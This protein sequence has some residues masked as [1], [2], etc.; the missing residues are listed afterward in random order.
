MSFV[1]L[2]LE[3][4]SYAAFDR[5]RVFCIVSKMSL[6]DDLQLLGVSDSLRQKFARSFPELSKVMPLIKDL[7]EELKK[8][9][10]EL[11][12][13]SFGDGR[14]L[15]RQR[16]GNSDSA[17]SLDESQASD[18]SVLVLRNLSCFP[19]RTADLHVGKRSLWFH[20]SK[21]GVIA[22]L[23]AGEGKL[24]GICL[25]MPVDTSDKSCTFFA[26]CSLVTL[27]QANGDNP[28]ALSLCFKLNTVDSKSLKGDLTYDRPA[29]KQSSITVKGGSVKS[30]V[31]EL[32]SE[33][34]P[35][36]W[37]P[38][39]DICFVTV[40]SFGSSSNASCFACKRKVQDSYVYLLDE[41]FL[42]GFGKPIMYIPLAHILSVRYSDVVRSSF[43]ATLVVKHLASPL[44][45]TQISHTHYEPLSR[46]FTRHFPHW[47]MAK[48]GTLGVA[49]PSNA[50]SDEKAGEDKFDDAKGA[51][52]EDSDA[53]DESDDEYDD[54][55]DDEDGEDDDESDESDDG[56]ESD[57]SDRDD[58]DSDQSILR[59]SGA[60][61][62]SEEV[63]DE[64]A[65][66]YSSEGQGRPSPST[67]G[68]RSL[69]LKS[70]KTDDDEEEIGSEDT[71]DLDEDEEDD[72]DDEEDDDDDDEDDKES[73]G[74][75]D[76][77]EDD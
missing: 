9:Y 66:A 61:T 46:Y 24:T 37:V 45:L 23:T 74:E 15:K 68:N 65:E 28:Y 35:L 14:A 31:C 75:D 5:R 33:S 32:L 17:G 2:S 59:D 47:K 41:G 10:S 11:G 38:T 29:I 1:L 55:E 16:L 43:T 8:R 4:Q 49:D 13:D 30:T 72:D 54:S 53:S 63:D 60:E 62:K 58:R 39:S 7:L 12:M 25:P 67:S 6:E 26:V 19:R 36:R 56:H 42:V 52:S 77:D 64:D 20:T 70:V 50:S 34:L 40:N 22:H 48:D 3:L 57:E 21:D 51:S 44:E 71:E 73:S 18:R 76:D 27:G 69:A